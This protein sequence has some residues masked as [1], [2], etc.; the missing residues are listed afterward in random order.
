MQRNLDLVRE[1]LLAIEIK[2]WDEVVK[3]LVEKGYTEEQIGFH[4]YLIGD[5]GFACISDIT[6]IHDSIPNATAVNL[7]WRGYEFLDSAREFKRWHKV[8]SALSKI[9]GGTV[10]VAIDLLKDYIKNDLG[11]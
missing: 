8:Q 5:A 6:A 2:S 3:S 1:L 11:I 7:T 9:G 4:C 10:D